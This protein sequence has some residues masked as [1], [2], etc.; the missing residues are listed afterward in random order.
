MRSQ[1]RGDGRRF[2]RALSR[3]LAQPVLQVHG[4][5]DPCFLEA[6]ARA[7]GRWAPRREYQVLP[8]CGHFPHQEAPR[9]TNRLITDFLHGLGG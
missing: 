2:A 9:A 6:T 7:S 4:A 5:L 3:T 8:D 1:V